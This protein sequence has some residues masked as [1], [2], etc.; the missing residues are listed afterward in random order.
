[1]PGGLGGV[2]AAPA[3]GTLSGGAGGG[4]KDE[5]FN[6]PLLFRLL[7]V[8]NRN[9]KYEKT[10]VLA[11]TVDYIVL[12]PATG[13]FEEVKNVTIMQKNIR[14]DL[15]AEYQRGVQAVAAVATLYQGSGDNPA[16]VL[17]QLDDTNAGGYLAADA[18]AYLRQAAIDQ[19][20]WWAADAA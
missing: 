6:K 2:G 9:S 1:M 18:L 11:P 7:S 15:V 19:F 8:S 14:N 10:E 20:H 5:H 3:I 16:K 12:D 17:R 4:V 13:T